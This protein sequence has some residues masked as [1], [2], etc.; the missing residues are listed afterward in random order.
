ML[1]LF[2]H[3]TKII[4]DLTFF[5]MEPWMTVRLIFSMISIRSAKYYSIIS[6]I[7]RKSYFTDYP[8]LLWLRLKIPIIHLH[9]QIRIRQTKDEVADDPPLNQGEVPYELY[10]PDE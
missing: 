7:V 3:L 6:K 5:E 9:L 10:L 1:M 4:S 8:K 2:L